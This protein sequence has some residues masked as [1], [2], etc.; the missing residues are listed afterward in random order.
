MRLDQFLKISRLVP[1]RSLAQELCEKGLVT[2]NGAT[3]KSSRAVKAGDEI[4]I[5][6]RSNVKT[7]VIKE[8]PERKQLSAAQAAEIIEVTLSAKADPHDYL[9]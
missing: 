4:T 2:V 5:T 3:A 9:T 6:G 8:V 1:R 7:A